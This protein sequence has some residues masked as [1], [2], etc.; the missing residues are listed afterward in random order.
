[1]YVYEYVCS[2]AEVIVVTAVLAMV[3]V[4]FWWVAGR[5]GLACR[6]VS[7]AKADGHPTLVRTCTSLIWT[8]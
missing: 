5:A 3:V 1:M 4:V 8:E 2:W 7:G 6:P